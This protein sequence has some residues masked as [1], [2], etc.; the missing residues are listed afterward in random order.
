MTHIGI[1][2]K[3]DTTYEIPIRGLPQGGWCLFGGCLCHKL[4]NQWDEDECVVA[5]V[6]TGDIYHLD[7]GE[8]VLAVPRIEIH[9]YLGD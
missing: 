7:G 4:A 2:E 1:I 9:Y 5:A 3:H 8:R 6:K